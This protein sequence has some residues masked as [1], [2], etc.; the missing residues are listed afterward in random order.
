MHGSSNV[1]I[2]AF[3]GAAS[4]RQAQAGKCQG[5][6][7]ITQ[8]QNVSPLLISGKTVSSVWTLDFI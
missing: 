8:C 7:K 2:P 6:V 1:K 3:A 4:R 5:D